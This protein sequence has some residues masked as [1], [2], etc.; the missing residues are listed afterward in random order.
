M[1]QTEIIALQIHR[2]PTQLFS[3]DTATRGICS[4]AHSFVVKSRYKSSRV[5]KELLTKTFVAHWCTVS[6]ASWQPKPD[7]RRTNI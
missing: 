5:L 7:T 2:L 3:C 4:T 1:Q 6:F